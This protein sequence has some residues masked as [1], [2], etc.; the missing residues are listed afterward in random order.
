MRSLITIFDV[1]D[2]MACSTL[3]AHT[4]PRSAAFADVELAPL[5]QAAAMVG[6]GLAHEAT[7]HGDTG[8][9]LLAQI[10]RRPDYGN[11][12]VRQNDVLT[13]KMHFESLACC[14]LT[15]WTV[16]VACGNSVAR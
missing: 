7:G 4:A 8:D 9:M 12:A 3:L 13:L 1:Q 11:G 6:L 15:V 16:G 5:T 10:S 14:V 2:S